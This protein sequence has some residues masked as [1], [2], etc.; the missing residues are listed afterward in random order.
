MNIGDLVGGKYRLV[1]RLGAGAMGAVWAAVNERTGRKVALK[2]ILHPTDDLR[3]RLVREARAC[4]SLDHRNIVE[5]Y[6]VGETEGGD[7]F[8]VMQLLH[9][10]TLAELLN[11]R[12]SIPPPLAVRIG[13]DIA[14]ALSAAHEARIVH[15]D[16]KP[17]NI[18][19]CR[20][21]GR[22][23]ED[24]FVLKVLDFGVSKNLAAGDVRATATGMV[25]GSPA[26]MSP[27]QIRMSRDVDHRTDIWSLGIILF[28][29]LTGARP[30]AGT[31]EEMVSQVLVAPIPPVSSRVRRVPPELDAIVARCLSRERE[32]R[33]RDANELDRALAAYAEAEHAAR[34]TSN[35]SPS[36]VSPEK[37]QILSP[38][39]PVASPLPVWRLEMRQALE[40]RREPQA[41][42]PVD[43]AES[44]AQDPAKVIPATAP[45]GR[46]ATWIHATAG[47]TAIAA[48]LVALATWKTSQGRVDKAPPIAP[49]SAQQ[50]ESPPP[51]PEPVSAPMVAPSPVSDPVAAPP[52]PRK[53][54]PAIT[55]KPLPPRAPSAPRRCGRFVKPVDKNCPH[56]HT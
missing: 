7:P 17:A 14:G 29:M 5:I 40:A 21:G 41:A 55:S 2:L 3:V 52:D 8:L 35:P 18:F 28:E 20:D 19:V 27:E 56:D 16:L 32:A 53:P 25:I 26:Y 34:R 24:A 50:P 9:G 43:L 13:R 54:A 39:D 23:D 30:F 11:R 45:V 4:G 6:D 38:T 22:G 31:V 49:S 1:Q 10:E 51:V 36:P 42:P 12:R 33:Y 48:L 37:T 44:P 15:R 47:G 46:G